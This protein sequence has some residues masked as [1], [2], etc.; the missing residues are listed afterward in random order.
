LAGLG[1]CLLLL[2]K[3]KALKYSL[4]KKQNQNNNKPNKIP[5]QTTSSTASSKCSTLD[6]C[7]HCVTTSGV[8]LKVQLLFAWILCEMRSLGWWQEGVEA[9][10]LSLCLQGLACRERP[11]WQVIA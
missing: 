8:L 11:A 6:V 3:H 1:D 2:R 7:K 9:E 5:K 4:G 10:L